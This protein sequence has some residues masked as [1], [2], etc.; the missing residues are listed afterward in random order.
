MF[1]SLI[2]S[3]LQEAIRTFLR[4][5]FPMTS[6]A[7]RRSKSGDMVSDFLAKPD[8]LF[9]GPYLSLGLPFRKSP[10]AGLPFR[11]LAPEFVPYRHQLLSFQRLCEDP[12]R[13]TLVATGTGSGKTECFFLPILDHCIRSRSAGIKAI[14]IY[15]MNA[16]A[17][18]QSRR[19][20]SEIHRNAASKGKVRVGLYVGDRESSP[21]KQ[22]S[23]DSVITC[24]ET[25]RKHPPDILLTNYRML[26]FLLM[27][28]G[29]QALW[30]HNGENQLRFL[31]V[32]ELHSFDGAQGTDLACLIR[33]LRK[34]LAS[35]EELACVGTSA[36]IGGE[37]NARALLDYAGEVFAT[38]FED[39]ALILED[40][41]TP[42][43]F[44]AGSPPGID[45]WPT[46]TTLHRLTASSAAN[47]LDFLQRT[48][49]LWLGAEAPQLKE[50]SKE[51]SSRIEL[52]EA[53]CRHQAVHELL[54]AAQSLVALDHLTASWQ[55]RFN[56]TS[57]RIRLM[58]DGLLALLSWARSPESTA[59]QEIPLVW[60]RLQL[61]LRE[62][63]RLTATI[64]EKPELLFNDD[65]SGEDA[66]FNLPVAHCRECHAS[67][68]VALRRSDDGR[69][70]HDLQ[71]IY[72]GWF[73]SDPEVCLMMP[74]EADAEAQTAYRLCPQCRKLTGRNE[75]AC[76]EC[77]SEKLI[78]VDV[79]QMT[80]EAE[81]KSSRSL[82]FTNRCPSCDARNSLSLMGSRAASLASVLIGHLYASRF[83]DHHKL[84]AFS[85]SVQDAAHRAGFFGA[86]TYN[87]TV[88]AA[89]AALIESEGEGQSLS[90]LAERAPKF[91]QQQLGSDGDFVGTFIAPNMTWL[92]DY[93]ALKT[94]PDGQLPAGSNLPQLVAKRL[95]WEVFQA[96]G[97]RA[98]IGRTL[99]R[100]GLAAVGLSIETLENASHALHR[101]WTEELGQLSGLRPEQVQRFLTGFLW[102][103]R[104]QGGFYHRFLD[105]VIEARG[106]PFVLTFSQFMPQYGL[107]V[108]PPALLTLEPV[109]PYYTP[110]HQQKASWFYQWFTKTIATDTAVLAIA[111]YKQTMS[112]LLKHLTQIGLLVEKRTGDTAVWG[113]N[114]EEWLVTKQVQ[115]LSCGKCGHRVQVPAG[116]LARWIE[117]DCLRNDCDGSYRL[118][119]EPRGRRPAA[120]GLPRRLVPAEHTGLLD[121]DKRLGIEQSFMRGNRPWHVNLLS[122]TPT[123]EMGIDVGGLST[124]LLC[125]VPPAQANYLQRVGRAGRHDGNSLA[126]TVANGHPHDLHFFSDPTRMIAGQVEPPGVFLQATAVLERQLLAFCFDHWCRSG[127]EGEVI[128]MQLGRVLNQIEVNPAEGFPANFLTFVELEADLIFS[129]FCGVFPELSEK[130]KAHLQRCLIGDEDAGR[131]ELSWRLTNRFSELVQTRRD[132]GRRIEALKKRIKALE[133]EPQDERVAEELE[134]TRAERQA[135]MALRRRINEQHIFNFFTDEGMLPN[136]AFPEEG[137]TLSSVIIR[138]KSQAERETPEG[139]KAYDK[140]NFELQR[141]AQSALSEL[142][143][144]S[145][146]YVAGRAFDIDQVDLSAGDTRPQAWRLCDNCHYMENIDLSGDRHAAC[147]RCGSAQWGDAGQ[148]QEMLKLRQVY[149]TVDDRDSRIGD[150]SEQRTP[151]FFNQQVLVDIDPS[152]SGPAW[153]LQDDTLPFG[154]EY[155]PGATL[156]EVNFGEPKASQQEIAVAGEL[157]SRP[158]FQICRH[159]G[160]VRNQKGRRKRGFEH[161]FDCKLSKPGAVETEEDFFEALYLYR[162]LKS[163]AVRILLPM[164]EV[165]RSDIKRRSLIAALQLGLRQHFKGKVDHIRVA[166]YSEPIQGAQGRRQYLVLYDGVPGGTGYLKELMGRGETLIAVMQSALEVLR[167]CAC[168]DDPS[169]DGCYRCLLAYRESRHLKEI[170]RTEAENLLAGIVE[171]RDLLKAI[172]HL[173]EVPVNSLLE[174]EL[175]QRFCDALANAPGIQIRQQRV[176]GTPGAF[177]QVAAAAD[178][179]SMGWYLQPQV[180]LGTDQ[181]V[182]VGT[183]ADFV[184]WP[185]RER[186]GLLPV[187]IYMDGF[188]HHFDRSDD[189]VLKRQSI[190]DSGN[191]RVWSLNWHDLP[192]DHQQIRNPAG[193]VLE[194][195]HVRQMVTVFDRLAVEGLWARHLS[196]SSMIADGPF[197]W[198]LRYLRGRPDDLA[199]LEQAAISRA[200]CWLNPSTTRDSA[201]R[202]A[203]SEEIR[204]LCPPHIAEEM[205]ADHE[206]DSRVFGGQLDRLGTSEG[207]LRIAASLPIE[208]MQNAQQ[209]Q[210]DGLQKDISL[211]LT[212]LD[213]AAAL[214]EVYE[215]EW[216]AFWGCA[217][218]L[219]FAPGFTLASEIGL[220]RGR[221]PWPLGLKKRQSSASEVT[222]NA[223]AD[224]KA[225]MDETLF[226]EIQMHALLESGVPAPS[227]GLD[228]QDENLGV[229]AETELSWP[230][231]KIAVVLEPD[232]RSALQERD[233]KIVPDLSSQSIDTLRNWMTTA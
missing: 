97:L 71:Q 143:P 178:D 90:L 213:E 202:S 129:D 218:L 228:V 230:G 138:R 51:L 194:R 86:R 146:F 148:K 110:L 153:H 144:L 120:R 182:A 168:R 177:V 176:N 54:E 186:A 28:P 134:N 114:P 142:A 72:R 205:G 80:R 62:L 174:S 199:T 101:A 172:P 34:R 70:T 154:F 87:N 224:W 150:E 123:L 59:D 165:G 61:W 157:A 82:L 221:Y 66:P 12:P 23:A 211:H 217:N 96:F 1:P 212:L 226:S 83:N 56:L 193:P 167:N 24:K 121:A 189:D 6:P 89:L 64:S 38:Q 215:R 159:C 65:L 60:M 206:G 48:A 33:R 78:P 200:L 68:W 197:A 17:T 73:G 25:L 223:P 232:D 53:L 108:R 31:V 36:T 219:Q 27:R 164:T 45:I 185:A 117:L 207:A 201:I 41:L 180:R 42:Q 166:S 20:A 170:S 85:D 4:A 105:Q 125:S 203:V 126:L 227:V 158:G 95:E 11:A 44:L 210:F 204:T 32:D 160:K 13:S 76:P 192:L 156:R 152:T 79:P 184:L 2:A 39:E 135:L 5:S 55:Q 141:P 18:D 163:E 128:P 19:F 131:P 198:L 175:E 14:I 93:E 107:G 9:R 137:V 220:Q 104:T 229:V 179:E 52:A 22:M 233:W 92:R 208:A 139:G 91:W 10:E 69:L 50:G 225:I 140:I 112:L 58:L 116:D 15:P 209:G 145:T 103:L 195:A 43:E 191:F 127:V 81:S 21:A 30:K 88:R 111:D 106:K 173:Q 181:D 100:Q 3:E 115:N 122:A 124:V 161:A 113:M 102:R 16:L 74:L 49:T 47:P 231:A 63:N 7:F 98:R 183:D 57:E 151:R 40:R 77:N 132:W 136:Y 222:Q 35:E 188:R 26:D 37:A 171:R 75:K 94:S 196:F 130:A 155:V 149:A 187:A 190:M 67:G 119:S 214:N 99:E 133:Q 46:E 29:D 109:S 84:I 169:L 147:P 216:A 8:R 118:P 162:E